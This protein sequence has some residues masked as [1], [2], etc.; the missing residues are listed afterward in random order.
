MN[1][2]TTITNSVIQTINENVIDDLAKLGYGHDEAVKMVV[3]SDFDLVFSAE[4]NPVAD[5]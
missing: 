5:F 3:E 4:S 1:T 2:L